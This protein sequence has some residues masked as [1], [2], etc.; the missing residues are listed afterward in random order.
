MRR[1]VKLPSFVMV[2]PSIR[3]RGVGWRRAGYRLARTKE[4]AN[5]Y[6]YFPEPDLPPLLISRVQVEEIRGNLS[7]CR[8][9]PRTLQ[10]GIGLSEQDANVMTEDKSLGDYFEHVMNASNDQRSPGA[11][12]DC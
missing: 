6:R 10:G 9:A 11:R 1:S 7:D 5:D 4:K 12:Q 2:E 8:S 3:R